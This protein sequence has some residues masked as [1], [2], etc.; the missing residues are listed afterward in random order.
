MLGQQ[1][2][3]ML[4]GRGCGDRS[5]HRIHSKQ[6]SE[7]CLFC[8]CLANRHKARNLGNHTGE[9]PEGKEKGPGRLNLYENPMGVVE[10]E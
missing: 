6:E 2:K 8:V 9:E 1:E 4:P 5:G 7:L 10:E 3:T